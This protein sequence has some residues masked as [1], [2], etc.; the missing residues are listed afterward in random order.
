MAKC[1]FLYWLRRLELCS[2]LVNYLNDHD[3]LSELYVVLQYSRRAL[4]R[5]VCYIYLR[6]Q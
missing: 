1:D 3:L 2:K 5:P 6:Q 4:R